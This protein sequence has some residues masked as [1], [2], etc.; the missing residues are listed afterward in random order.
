MK[1]FSVTLVSV[2]LL[3][4]GH[5]LPA[6]ADIVGTD[7]A[8]AAQERQ[9]LTD[10][11][12]SVLTREDVAR[13]LERYGVDPVEARERVAS[14]TDAELARVAPHL[15]QLPAGAG[16]VEVVGIVFVVLLILELVGVTNVFTGL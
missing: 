5:V 4:G 1:R 6:A 3:A 7:R 13:E 9:T 14:L 2:S 8:M 10:R 15:D 11:L 16:V 12:R